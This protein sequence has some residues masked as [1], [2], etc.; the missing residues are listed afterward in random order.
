[1][2][3]GHHG[4]CFGAPTQPLTGGERSRLEKVGGT[5]PKLE[6]GN[7]GGWERQMPTTTDT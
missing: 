5:D 6:V 3:F 4:R 1:M 2:L 7:D